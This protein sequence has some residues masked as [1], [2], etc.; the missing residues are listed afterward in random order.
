MHYDA[1][2]RKLKYLNMGLSINV[3]IIDYFRLD[4]DCSSSCA[5][6]LR[7]SALCSRLR[8]LRTSR[9]Y[10]WSTS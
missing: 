3:E 5:A 6:T 4:L 7:F 10:D 1:V 2:P 9:F 8:S